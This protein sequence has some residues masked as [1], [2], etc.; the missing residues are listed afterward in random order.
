MSTKIYSV[1]ITIGKDANSVILEKVACKKLPPHIH[2]ANYDF[3]EWLM[4]KVQGDSKTDARWNKI[5]KDKITGLPEVKIQ[6]L[7]YLGDVA[8]EKELTF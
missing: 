7:K 8:S 3:I 6:Y 5:K 1:N 2:L 4:R